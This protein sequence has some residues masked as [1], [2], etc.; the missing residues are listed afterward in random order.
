MERTHVA[1][2]ED[3]PTLFG[4]SMPTVSWFVLYL[5]VIDTWLTDRSLASRKGIELN[6]F[7]DWL[8]HSWGALAFLISKVALTALCLLWIN[9]RA[10]KAQARVAALVA[11]AIYVPVAGIHI[12]GLYR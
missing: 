12:V 1:T 5:V 2:V 6:P 7:M 3:K 11:L 8:Y 10:P 4:L 9:R